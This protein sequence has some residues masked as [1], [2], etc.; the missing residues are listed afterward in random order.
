MEQVAFSKKLFQ[1][2]IRS[3][4]CQELWTGSLM[5]LFKNLINLSFHK[6]L[7]IQALIKSDIFI[8]QTIVNLVIHQIA[9]YILLSMVADK[10]ENFLKNIMLRTL[11]IW[12]GQLLMITSFFFLKI[13]DW[14]AHRKI[15]VGVGTFGVIQIKISPIKKEFKLPQLKRWQTGFYRNRH[16]L[17]NLCFDKKILK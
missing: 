2:K 8:Y 6:I 14:E 10:V 3:P 16:H 12:N 15:Q 5:G 1:T 4:C 9:C 7:Q 11:G 13:K 17:R